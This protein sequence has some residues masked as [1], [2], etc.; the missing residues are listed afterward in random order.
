MKKIKFQ[1]VALMAF[2]AI[3][4]ASCSD[5]DSNTSTVLKEAFATEVTGPETG[6]VNQELTYTVK[7]AVDNE[8]GLFNRYVET[9]SGTTKTIGIQ[10]KYEANNC[11]AAAVIKDTI[12]KFKP[13]AAGTYSLKFKKSAT[14]F[15]TKS[16]AVD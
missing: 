15:V 13:T 2:F 16:V 14:E 6:D 4:A 9:T 7:Y 12:Y 1:T 3:G 10:A 8:C 5:D 11:E